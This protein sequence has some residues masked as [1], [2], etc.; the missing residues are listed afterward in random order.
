MTEREES[1]YDTG[2]F[3]INLGLCWP[4]GSHRLDSQSGQVAGS[5]WRQEMSDDLP[6]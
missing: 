1:N 6:F 5:Y 3:V 2:N 4:E